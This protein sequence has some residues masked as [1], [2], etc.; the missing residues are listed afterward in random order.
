[1]R[2][3]APGLAVLAILF[4]AP[5]TAGPISVLVRAESTAGTFSASS[6]SRPDLDGPAVAGWAHAHRDGGF[7]ELFDGATLPCDY[8]L[9]GCAFIVTPPGGHARAVGNGADGSL[10]V[11]AAASR[12]DDLGSGEALA[13][14]RLED[15]ITFTGTSA[16]ID[17]YVDVNDF[18]VGTHGDASLEYVLLHQWDNPFGEGPSAAELVRIDVDEDGY[19]VIRQG[20]VVASGDGVPWSGLHVSL[21]LTPFM[22][23]PFF[24]STFSL[25]SELRADVDGPAL[26]RADN[27]AYLQ[28]LSPYVS[29][30]GFSYPGPA[31]TPTPTPVP[32]PAT[33]LFLLTG[34]ALA[35]RRKLAAIRGALRK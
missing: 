8:F 15:T 31:Q 33:G 17:V 28:I 5:A 27:S 26:V 25:M 11:S 23:L 9:T 7:A 19:G 10:R 21:D 16:L 4:S 35:G 30:N 14:A 34:A 18:F 3:I 24:G 6:S 29:A 13:R 12:D 20:E 22:T 2:R 1:M 32:E